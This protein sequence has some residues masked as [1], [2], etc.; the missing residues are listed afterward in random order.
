MIS[1]PAMARAL[2]EAMAEPVLSPDEQMERRV[3]TIIREL[4]DLCVFAKQPETAPLVAKQIVA[5]GQM[6]TRVDLIASFL[7]A[8]EQP[9]FKVIRHG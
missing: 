2:N 5:I 4:D 6:K 7:L 3:D 8:N 1:D 9:K